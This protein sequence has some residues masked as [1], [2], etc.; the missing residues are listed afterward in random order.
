MTVLE[1][2]EKLREYPL[3]MPVARTD[4]EFGPNFVEK[5]TVESIP[6]YHRRYTEDNA[7]WLVLH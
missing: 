1:L 3:D 7:L 5:I 6:H 4:Y 2:L